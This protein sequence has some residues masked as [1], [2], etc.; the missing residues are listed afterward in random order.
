MHKLILPK[1]IIIIA[2]IHL[3]VYSY[4]RLDLN[5]NF[6]LRN[7]FWTY[8]IVAKFTPYRVF[9]ILLTLLMNLQAA[10]NSW[11]VQPDPLKDI[12]HGLSTL[13][14]MLFRNHLSR[15]RGEGDFFFFFCYKTLRKHAKWETQKTFHVFN[16]RNC[17][18]T[19]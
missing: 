5:I 15:H 14:V 4:D 1:I 18:F 7:V 9:Y 19:Q 8:I 16:R 17:I 11:I 3:S 2:W 6:G 12:H 10:V 13:Y